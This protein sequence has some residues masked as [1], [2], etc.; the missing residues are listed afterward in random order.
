MKVLNDFP[1][2]IEVF[3][4]NIDTRLGTSGMRRSTA[5]ALARWHGEHVGPARKHHDQLRASGYSVG[6]ISIV[7]ISRFLLL[8]IFVTLIETLLSWLSSRSLF[9]E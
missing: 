6:P 3:R 4:L 8:V 9:L 1:H 5:F 7:V 2:E